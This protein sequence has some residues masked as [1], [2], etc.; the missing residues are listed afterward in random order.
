VAHRARR[1]AQ[2]VQAIAA[3]LP[4]CRL[5]TPVSAVRRGA[6]HVMV[7]SN[8]RGEAF[9]D[10]VFATHAPTTLSLL[11]DAS[12]RER[13]SRRRALSAQYRLAAHRCQADA[14]PAQGLVGLELPVVTADDGS[15]PV[16]VSYW[17]NQL[18][19]A[20]Q[21]PVVVTLNPPVAPAADRAGA[22]RLRAPDHRPAGHRRPA[23]AA[24]DPGLGGA[25]F[26][27]AWTG[28]GFHEDGLKSALRIAAAFDAAPAWTTL[29]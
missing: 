12:E 17:L 22:L 13:A 11:V 3:T 15:R 18:Q 29:P 21:Q 7:S 26:A 9:D 16:C 10:V 1:L 20:V 19:P 24:G 8:G 28:Y 6:G 25:W 5:N 23:R 2:Y 14:A 4:D 27:G